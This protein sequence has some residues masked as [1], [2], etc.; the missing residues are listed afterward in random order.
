MRRRRRE[1]I[2]KIANERIQILFRLAEEEFDKHPERSHRYVSLA[3]KISMRHRV[4]M[5]KW[6]KRRI[7]KGCGRFLVYGKNARV[8]LK[9]RRTCITCLECGR[10]MR[11]PYK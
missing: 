7:C 5:P 11:Y 10:V 8:R 4:R 9:N 2:K 1:V 3:R 6:L